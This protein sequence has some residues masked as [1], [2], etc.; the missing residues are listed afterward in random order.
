MS[1]VKGRNL[2]FFMSSDMLEV[3]SVI[4]PESDV[5]V[6]PLK[7]ITRGC[8]NSKLPQT[9]WSKE[10]KKTAMNNGDIIHKVIIAFLSHQ[11]QQKRKRERS[12]IICY[13]DC[14][15]RAPDYSLPLN[16]YL[17]FY[18]IQ[19]SSFLSI[20]ACSSHIFSL[21]FLCC[22]SLLKINISHITPLHVCVCVD[23]YI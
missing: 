16:I 3:G 11:R 14:R 1:G 8:S 7:F 6:S 10:H 15:A 17:A 4:C 2:L 12:I 20:Q 21:E 13:L 18:S 19:S 23:I 5:H 22:I 9:N